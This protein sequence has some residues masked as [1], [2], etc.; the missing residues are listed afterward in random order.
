M[1]R[2][3]H[4]LG[5][6]PYFYRLARR[7]EP[8]LAIA[9]LLLIAWGV[10]GGLVK[11]P[12]DYQQG[13]AFR[14]IYVHVP[15]AWLS[16]F[17]Y[18]AMAVAGAVALVWR[19]KLAEVF[20]TAAA[21]LGAAFTFLALV[22]GSIWGKPMW[23]TWWVWDARLTSE[24]ILLFLYLGV[25]ALNAAI[26]D[27]RS[28]A[29]ACALLALVGVINVPIVHYSVEWWN[30]LHQGPT[31][32]RFD[33]PAMAPEMLWP[34]LWCALGF[35]FLF[36]WLQLPRMRYELLQREARSRWVARELGSE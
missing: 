16:L 8:R 31:I 11:A 10:Y 1:Y 12:P 27:R 19:M 22:T 30:T 13:E 15:S 4:Q 26:E 25:I 14:I 35:N 23:G 24:L 28:A 5:S 3:F 9:A 2:W 32:T 33:R 34:L 21:P 7:L 36:F 17:V 29:R 18:T 6:P 20:V